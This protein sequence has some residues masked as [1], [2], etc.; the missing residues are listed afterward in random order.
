MGDNVGGEHRLQ[1]RP[2]IAT[3]NGRSQRPG[4]RNGAEGTAPFLPFV[5]K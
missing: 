1:N 4:R 5:E 3:V 2:L